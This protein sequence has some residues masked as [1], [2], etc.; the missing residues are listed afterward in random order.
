MRGGVAS[1]PRLIYTPVAITSLLVA[2][3]IPSQTLSRRVCRCDT[4]GPVHDS[5]ETLIDTFSSSSS[6]SSS[7]Q[8]QRHQ[9]DGRPFRPDSSAMFRC[10]G[11]RS[12]RAPDLSSAPIPRALPTKGR[13]SLP[14]PIPDFVPCQSTVLGQWMDSANYLYSYVIAARSSDHVH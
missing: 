9:M 13:P 5:Y 14:W 10:Y 8:D 2:V 11:N 4:S 12:Q 7:S 1:L 6:S 3:F